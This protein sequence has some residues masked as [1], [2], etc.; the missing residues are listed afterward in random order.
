MTGV[1][2]NFNQKEL[3]EI[4]TSLNPHDRARRRRIKAQA[5]DVRI[6]R[7]EYS[8]KNAKTPEEAARFRRLLEQTKKDYFLHKKEFIDA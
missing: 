1:Y 5:L 2:T 4:L 6:Q 8:L 7:L 3:E